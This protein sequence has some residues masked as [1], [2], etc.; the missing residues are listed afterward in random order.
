MAK[1]LHIADIHLGTNQYNSP[2]NVRKK[3][4]FLG[5]KDVVNRYAIAEQVDFVLIAGDLF[6]KSRIDPNTLNQ[7]IVVLDELKEHN[8]PVFAIEGNHD[9]HW[10][11]DSVSWLQFLG[12]QHYIHFLRADYTDKTVTFRPLS[13]D[14]PISGYYELNDNIRIIGAQWFGANTAN[15][16][17][18]IAESIKKLGE[19]PFTIL[20]LH[21]GI[22]GYLAGYGTISK[23]SLEP[24]K[25][26]VNYLALGHIHKHYIFD[27]WAYNP[28]SL[29]ACCIPEFF[30]PHG[31]ILVN[32]EKDYS[33]TVSLKENYQKR[34]FIKINVDITKCNT[35]GSVI[36]KINE[37]ISDH[38]KY[39]TDNPVVEI[40]IDGTLQFNRSELSIDSIK[41]LAQEGLNAL[42]VLVKNFARSKE[43]AV[44]A[45]LSD[46]VSRD[47]VEFAVIRDMVSQYQEYKK[48][49][50]EVANTLI[51]LKNMVSNKD[52]NEEIYQYICSSLRN[53]LNNNVH[54]RS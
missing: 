12:E 13:E 43:Y 27:D 46:K 7:A 36:K 18:A 53:H 37:S 49:N 33:V 6:D 31:A 51:T 4:F 2:G 47:K 16:I 34:T 52:N 14:S 26:Y 21:A 40:V 39:Q 9:S 3:D 1:F 50:M 19:Y 15:I 35:Y 28:G 25:P 17:P 42:V 5:F 23:A 20:M 38:G 8:I 29:E 48:V 24:L 10:G 54:N 22:E 45:N 32:I 11:N 41:T 44:G 30:D